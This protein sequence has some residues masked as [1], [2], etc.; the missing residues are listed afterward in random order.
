MQFPS[1]NDFYTAKILRYHA[2]LKRLTKQIARISLARLV[3]F[4][5]MAGFGFYSL[6]GD[7]YAANGVPHIGLNIGL[8]ISSAA[9]ILLVTIH[10]RLFGAKERIESLHRV[11]DEELRALQGDRAHIP[12]GGEFLSDTSLPTSQAYSLD[13]DIFGHASLFQRMNRTGTAL[14]YKRLAE[15]LTTPLTRKEEIDARQRMIQELSAATSFREEWQSAKRERNMSL[16]EHEGLRVW[17]QKE[18]LFSTHLALSAVIWILPVITLICAG[19]AFWNVFNDVENS[20]WTKLVWGCMIVQFL[21]FALFLRRITT[22]AALLKRVAGLL[23]VYVRLFRILREHGVSA[24]SSGAVP[25][26]EPE[27]ASM[28][29]VSDRAW[30]S[31]RELASAMNYFEMGQ[32][33]VGAVLLNGTVFWHLH[34]VRILEQWRNRHGQ[35][36]EEW[37][38]VL[39][40]MDALCSM[41]GFVF[42]NP[43]YI[44]PLVHESDDFVFRASGLAHPFLDGGEAVRNTITLD[45]TMG[46]LVVIT[47]ANMA[48]KSTFLRA[49]GINAVLALVGLPVCASSFEVSVCEVLTSMRASDSLEKQESYF[50]AELKR[51]Q[52]IVERL[53]N[54]H[55]ALVILDEILRG[56]NSADKKSGTVGLLQQLISL[57]TLAVIATHDTEIGALE[58]EY[59]ALVR[60]YCFEGEIQQGELSFDYTLRRGVAHNKNATFLMQQMGIVREELSAN[61]SSRKA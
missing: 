42:N 11:N 51:L 31:I 34:C 7:Y 59:P 48:G 37:F 50:Y 45:K 24:S 14:G 53:R 10:A 22:E 26:H 6:Y 41:A 46:A 56:T 32:S 33:M 8:L 47:G 19:V 40:R 44:Q 57:P 23:G 18:N 5:A 15:W 35:E 43:T 52:F 54:G 20:P 12:H 16:G 25:F 38:D 21:F 3:S 30:K 1:P 13:L 27:L 39:A 17:L 29:A 60:N 49:I 9:F 2:D 55:R 61:F 4:I 28:V 36:V 58:T